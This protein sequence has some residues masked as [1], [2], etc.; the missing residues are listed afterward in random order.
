MGFLEVKTLRG[1]APPCS[2]LHSLPF[3]PVY[4]AASALGKQI[5][6]VC[7]QVFSG[8]LSYNLCSLMGS[9][10]IDFRFIFVQIEEMASK[11]FSYRS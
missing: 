8:S 1:A 5:S 4:G 2:R 10:V 9:K 3:R 7:L 6:A 11:S